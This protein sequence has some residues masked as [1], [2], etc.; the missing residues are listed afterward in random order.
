MEN[1]WKFCC[2]HRIHFTE[3]IERLAFGLWRW[4][5]FLVFI[6]CTDDF[7]WNFFWLF[8]MKFVNENILAW[9]SQNNKFLAQNVHEV[10]GFEPTI[11]LTIFFCKVNIFWLLGEL[12]SKNYAICYYRMTIDI[13]NS[14]CVMCCALLESFDQYGSSNLGA[15]QL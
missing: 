3:N 15:Y 11:I 12:P 1:C 4:C 6:L 13:T 14:Y 10:L 5:I 9:K 2:Q 7:V 8:T